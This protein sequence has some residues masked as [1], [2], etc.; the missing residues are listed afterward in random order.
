MGKIKNILGHLR[1]ICV[2][3]YWVYHFGRKL[4]VARWQLIMHDI[5]KLSLTEFKESV[6]YYRGNSSPIP[7]CKKENGFSWAWQHHKGRN[8]HHY[9]YWTDNYDGGGRTLIPMPMKYVGEM[10]ADWFAA[11]RTYEGKSYTFESQ[12]KWWLNKKKAKIALHPLTIELIDDFFNIP[13]RYTD[14]NDPFAVWK[15]LM[16]LRKKDYEEMLNNKIWK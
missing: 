3:K 15:H 13:Q 6:N 1:N 4:G 2:H 14:E 7:D 8:P 9:E 12:C 11:G 16:W 10:L 5:S